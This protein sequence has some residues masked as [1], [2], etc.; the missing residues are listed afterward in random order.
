[1]EAGEA[2]IYQAARNYTRAHVGLP[3]FIQTVHIDEEKCLCLQ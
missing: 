1:M 2:A 3:N